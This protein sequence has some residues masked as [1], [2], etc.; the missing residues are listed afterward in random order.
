MYD[1][2]KITI[3]EAIVFSL[4][5]KLGNTYEVSKE[6]NIG[7]AAVNASINN[8]EK[9]L[10]KILFERNRRTGRFLLTNEGSKISNYVK[11][12]IQAAM[13]ISTGPEIDDSSVIISSTHSIIEYILGPYLKT[14]KLTHPELKFSIQQKDSLKFEERKWNEIIITSF[15]DDIQNYYYIPYHSF[16]QKLWA[17][18]Q[19]I[20]ENGSPNSLDELVV[21]DLLMRKEVDEPRAL[22]GSS[23]IRSQLIDTKGLKIID[24]Y[25]ARIIDYLCEQNWGIMS[26]SEESVKLGDIKVH[27]VYPDFKGDEIQIFVGL[28]KEFIKSHTAKKILNWIFESRN[29]AL[30]KIGITP[31]YPFKPYS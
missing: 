12:L 25:G 17:S 16:K 19:Y 18:E 11:S 14:L 21:H 10:D 13:C 31:S 9:K 30:W 4:L 1:H 6:L 24:V 29:K 2:I 7:T 15:V 20:L 3:N 22:F 23:Y 26:S 27:N 8:L 5:E 28:S